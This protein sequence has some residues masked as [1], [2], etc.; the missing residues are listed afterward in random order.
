MFVET[1]GRGAIQ[2]RP[3]APRLLREQVGGW[4]WSG[5]ERVL[6]WEPL[7]GVADAATLHELRLETKRLRD[8]I[9]VTAPMAS[10]PVEPVVAVL[11][12]LQD[13]LGALNDAL[14]TAG[15]ARMYLGSKSAGL[16]PEESRAI[17]RFA[18]AQELQAA[19]L[20]GRI[21]GAWRA[22]A[23]PVTRHRVARLVGSF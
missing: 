17:E 6:A 18:E 5:F 22:A 21:P 23:S 1:P 20:R 13:A 15:T 10:A 8:V 2:A 7:V 12:T 16:S 19:Q 9:Q 14:V 3:P 4:I 11:V